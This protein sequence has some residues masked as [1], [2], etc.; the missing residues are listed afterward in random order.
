MDQ[1]SSSMKSFIP[2]KLLKAKQSA[3]W[4]NNS[5]KRMCKKKQ[6]LLSAARKTG[7][8]SAWTRYKAFKRDTL[9]AIR[10]ARWSYLNDVLSLSLGEGNSKPFWQ[11]I[12]AQRQDNIGISPLKE[13]GNLVSDALGKADILSRQFSSVFTKI[14]GGD[15]ARLAG[16]NY[17]QIDP[18]TI[19]QKGVEKLLAD[20]DPSKASGPDHIHCRFLKE[21][22]HELAPV[23]TCIFKQSIATATLPKVWTDA[24]VAPVFKKGPRCMPE[25]YRPVSL[26]CVPCKILEHIIAKHYRDHLERHGILN[27]INHGFRS[28]FSCETQLLLTLQDLLTFRDRKIQ[29]DIAILDFSKAFDTVPHDHLLEKLQFYGMHG[30]LLDWT[31]SFL[32][33]RTQ[34]VVADGKHSKP[35]KVLSGVPQCTVLGPLLFLLHINDLPS[36]VTSS[37]RLFADDCLLYRPVRCAADQVALQRDLL[38]LQ[39]WGDTWG[40]RFNAGKC[41][42]MQVHRGQPLVHFLYSMWASIIPSGGNI[43]SWGAAGEWPWLVAPRSFHSWQSFIRPWFP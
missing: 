16:P 2:T 22:A 7:K 17:P 31:A 9:K 36:V 25:N 41:H 11:Y 37:V 15:V 1:I 43:V 20:L 40:M 39:R 23:F 38:A 30:P 18:L 6:R 35:A 12:R 4:F 13:N 26:T 14:T 24:Y 32:K 33:T 27:S 10:K 21:T 29:V 28:K 42:I 5:I 19:R 3:P 34:S 8:P